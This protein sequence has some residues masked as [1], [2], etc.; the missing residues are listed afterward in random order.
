MLD[1]QSQTNIMSMNDDSGTSMTI[2]YLNL[3]HALTASVT[4]SP[5]FRVIA[6]GA[7]HVD[8]CCFRLDIVSRFS[9]EP[10]IY[11]LTV[12]GPV[13]FTNNIIANN[14][15]PASQDIVVFAL[16]TGAGPDVTFYA[17]NNTIADN[18]FDNVSQ[19]SG[20]IALEP[21]AHG[22]FANN[23][24]WGNG[25]A[26]FA[27]NIPIHPVLLNNDVDVLNITPGPGSSGNIGANPKFVNTNNHHLLPG[28]PAYNAGYAAPPGG[29]GVFDLDGNPRVAL[30][31]VDIGAYELQTEPDEIFKNGFDGA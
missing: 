21:G 14:T 12:N 24:R 23:I 13:Y 5:P 1:G 15:A 28:T 9:P 6:P 26:E 27:Q 16:N 29:Y 8:N 30:G 18:A 19:G 25:G 10:V 7:V 20:T 11:L 2:R 4:A 22:S 31:T 3:L 17:N